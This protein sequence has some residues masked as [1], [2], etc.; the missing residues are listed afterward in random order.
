MYFPTTR[1]H[2]SICGNI[3]RHLQARSMIRLR[4]TTKIFATA[5]SA[6]SETN[7]LVTSKILGMMQHPRVVH[8]LLHDARTLIPCS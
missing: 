4:A 5:Q 7:M 8:V 3:F 2:F 1:T 6:D